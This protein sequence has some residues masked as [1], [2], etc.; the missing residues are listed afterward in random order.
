M[1]YIPFPIVTGQTSGGGGSSVHNDLTGRTASDAHPTSAITGLDTALAGMTADLAGKAAASHSHAAADTTSGTF[2]AA[3]LGTGTPDGTKFLRDDSTWQ[4][5]TSGASALNDLSDVDVV[6]DPPDPDDVLAWD[7]GLSTWV[8]ATLSVIGDGFAP[9][10]RSITAGTGLTGGGDLSTDRTIA[11]NIGTTAGTVA[12]GDDAR[13]SD[14]RTPTAHTHAM[15]DVLGLD[16][17]LEEAAAGG[18]P[19]GALYLWSTTR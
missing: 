4:V 11:A 14:A 1:A 2:A 17:A 5:V 3:R 8:P 12:A 6:T 15:S 16:D 19:G 9:S 13:L 18:G 10:S 7:S